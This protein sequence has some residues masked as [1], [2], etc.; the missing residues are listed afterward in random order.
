MEKQVRNNDFAKISGIQ[1]NFFSCAKSK[2]LMQPVKY[3]KMHEKKRF[4]LINWE[5]PYFFLINVCLNYI[6][7][8]I[9]IQKNSTGFSNEINYT[10]KKLG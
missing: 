1:K 8:Q 4:F 9:V 6:F 2:F 7:L 5:E 3:Q 10:T